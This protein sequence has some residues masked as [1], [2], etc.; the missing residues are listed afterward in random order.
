MFNLEQSIAEW[1]RRMLAAGVKNS[2]VLDELENHLR[3]DVEKQV[4]EGSSVQQAFEA[5]TRQIGQANVLKTEFVKAK[6]H[7][8]FWGDSKSARTD[9]ILGVLWLAGCSLSFNTLCRQSIPPHSPG[10]SPDTA[11]ELMNGLGAFIYAAGILG[12]IFL[13]RGAEWGRSIVR[14][15]ALVLVIACVAHILTFSMPVAWRVWCGI[16]AIFGLVSIWLLN[17]PKHINPKAAK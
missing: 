10:T 17:S 4:R 13:L 9:C 6:S 14:M 15:I 1:R 11:F 7:F 3:E 12:S 8:R 2:N 16:V 5:A